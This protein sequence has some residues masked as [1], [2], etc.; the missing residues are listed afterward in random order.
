M[1]DHIVLYYN[2]ID[3]N[4]IYGYSM[5]YCKGGTLHH[6]IRTMGALSE[7]E[8]KILMRQMLSALE[9]LASRHIVHR[10]IKTANILIVKK[11]YYKLGDFGSSVELNVN[12]LGVT[13]S[14]RASRDTIINDG[15][16]RGTAQFM[17]PESAR[18]QQRGR[19]DV[20]SLG[21]CMYEA[22]TGEEPWSEIK[23]NCKTRESIIFEIAKQT[24]PPK[25]PDSIW[26]VLSDPLKDF[27]KCIFDIV[28]ESRAMIIQDETKRPS[29]SDLLKHPFLSSDLCVCY[30]NYIPEINGIL[31]N[32][33][34]P[35]FIHEKITEV[36]S[37]HSQQTVHIHSYHA[38]HPLLQVLE[39]LLHMEL[40]LSSFPPTHATKE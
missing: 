19:S 3:T 6:Y 11:D 25:V 35:Y 29:A 9:Y 36:P 17:A 16:F 37:I 7:E 5:E 33:Q 40:A 12:V 2:E 10:D 4:G 23:K 26:N 1:H 31:C 14:Q 21:C 24:K 34:E 28:C 38:T 27:Y 20:W 22:I 8:L 18:G 32:K 15:T 30:L 39:F 13:N